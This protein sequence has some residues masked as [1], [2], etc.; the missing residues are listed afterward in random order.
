MTKR[1]RDIGAELIEAAE[2]M[3]AFAKG[4]PSSVRIVNV[5]DDADVRGC[6][7]RGHLKPPPRQEGI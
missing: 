4:E 6:R 2:E 5:P 3:L 1:K 7:S